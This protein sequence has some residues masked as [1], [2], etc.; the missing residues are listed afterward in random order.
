MASSTKIFPQLSRIPAPLFGDMAMA[1]R[2]GAQRAKSAPRYAKWAV[3]GVVGATWFIWPAVGDDTKIILGLIKDPEL[4]AADEELKKKMSDGVSLDMEKVKGAGVPEVVKVSNERQ[5]EIAKEVV[6]D[7]THLHAQWDKYMDDAINGDEDDED[8][9]D[10]DEDEDG[11]DE[12]DEG[13]DDDDE[14]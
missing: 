12:E 6:G 9:D 7:Y 8:D 3:P 11:E 10:D 14:E 2:F 13:D 4:V 1:L 5:A